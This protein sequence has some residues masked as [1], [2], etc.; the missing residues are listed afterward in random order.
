[1]IVACYECPKCGH[2]MEDVFVESPASEHC[3]LC[4][5][6]GKRTIWVP[7]PPNVYV[8]EPYVEEHLFEKPVLIES[9]E[10][11]RTLSRE[12]GVTSAALE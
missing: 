12:R 1:M 11:L 4:S 6:C 9:K 10:H 3:P 7:K 8:F 5:K 2:E